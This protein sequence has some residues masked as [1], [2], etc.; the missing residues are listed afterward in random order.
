PLTPLFKKEGAVGNRGGRIGVVEPTVGVERLLLQALAVQHHRRQ[1]WRGVLGLDLQGVGIDRLD[2]DLVERHFAGYRVV[3]VLAGAVVGLAAGAVV[4]AAAGAVVAAA[5]AVVGLAAAAAGALVA[6]GG[7]VGAAG[8]HAVK[9]K[10]RLTRSEE[11]GFGRVIQ[12]FP[13][14][15]TGRYP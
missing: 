6:A 2:T 3:P 7:L 11:R 5:G 4:A 12:C 1:V 14:F 9:T 13:L 8:P 10:A 15:G